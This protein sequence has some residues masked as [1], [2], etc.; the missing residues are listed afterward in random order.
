MKSLSCHHQNIQLL[1][2]KKTPAQRNQVLVCL[3]QWS[4]H[5]SIFLSH[6]LHNAFHTFRLVSTVLTFISFLWSRCLKITFHS[7]FMFIKIIC[8]LKFIR[9]FC[10]N[11]FL[12]CFVYFFMYVITILVFLLIDSVLKWAQL[13][14]T[15]FVEFTHFRFCMGKHAPDFVKWACFILLK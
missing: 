9:I 4:H 3:V 10:S 1:N 15:N 5:H 13:V 11:F 6:T 7:H 8:K 2:R 14:T 12:I